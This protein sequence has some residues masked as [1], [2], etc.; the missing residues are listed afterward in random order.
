MAGDV[1]LEHTT[2][3]LETAT[4]PVKLIA[5]GALGGTRTHDP[6]IKSLQLYQ[7]S[8]ERMDFKNSLLQRL[9]LN[10]QCLSTPEPKSGDLPISL[11]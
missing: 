7:L 8:Y 11:R 6:K 1:R 3:V 4:L 10:Q 9:D 5:Y 2:T